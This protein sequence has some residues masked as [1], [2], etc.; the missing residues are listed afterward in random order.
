MPM[1][2]LVLTVIAPQI[3]AMPPV[4]ATVIGQLPL[5]APCNVMLPTFGADVYDG[6][7][8]LEVAFPQTVL[9]PAVADPRPP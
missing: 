7:V 1:A 3:V 4:A 9:E 8:E 5:V 2:P 6:V